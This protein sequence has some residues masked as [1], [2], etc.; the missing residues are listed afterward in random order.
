M[1]PYVAASYLAGHHIGELGEIYTTRGFGL[2]GRA[3]AAD[4]AF[5]QVSVSGWVLTEL[6][7]AESAPGSTRTD[8]S[9]YDMIGDVLM[10]NFPS[11]ASYLFA[12]FNLACQRDL[13][14][15]TMNNRID[16]WLT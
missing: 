2:I 12:R 16:W 1:L 14:I 15:L 4:D 6:Y 13:G 10:L 5:R 3:E 11:G 7:H 9:R 8:S